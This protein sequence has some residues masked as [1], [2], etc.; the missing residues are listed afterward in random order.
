MFVY[1]P[2]FELTTDY[3]NEGSASNNITDVWLYLDNQSVG[4]FQLPAKVPIYQ[5]ADSIQIFPGIKVNGIS[6]TRAPY[7]M[8]T[9]FN[10]SFSFEPATID[11][12]NPS[13]EYVA[14]AN[15]PLRE[16]FES[17]NVFSNIGVT[18]ATNLV[19]EGNKSAE[20]FLDV[21]VRTFVAESNT[22]VLPNDGTRLFLE[23]DYRN[24][25]RF[26]VLVRINEITGGQRYEYALS[27]NARDEWNKIYA[28]LT[29]LISSNP[30][31]SY[32]IVLTSELPSGET[33]ANFYWDNIKL[34][35]L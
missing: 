24:S 32:Q 30:A 17:G 12:F 35:H 1:I 29:S 4:V 7:P 25:A 9:S 26:D 27:V 20:A 18:S 10:E 5:D 31:L 14:G 11:T 33:E 6:N 2:Q 28:D 3:G 13:I 16:D 23:M 21:N 15:F 22:Y 34:V 8:Y 19:F